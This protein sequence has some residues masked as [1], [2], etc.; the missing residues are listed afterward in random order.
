MN[1][2]AL[3]KKEDIRLQG[4]KPFLSYR[5][6]VT[7]T[8]KQTEVIDQTISEPFDPAESEAAR[9][10]RYTGQFQ[11]LIDDLKSR[12]AALKVSKVALETT[13][14]NIKNGLSL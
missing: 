10:I 1:L 13:A 9:A 5:L 3:V 2:T 7:D 6:I 14:T 4:G 11:K 8:D 12:D